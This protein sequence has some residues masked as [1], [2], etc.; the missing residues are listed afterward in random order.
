MH[1]KKHHLDSRLLMLIAYVERGN[2]D[3]MLETPETAQEIGVSTG[4]LNHGRLN[5]YGPPATYLSVKKIRYRR[6]E[7]LD[8]LRG[9]QE[10][11]EA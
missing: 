1:P 8:W 11:A 3:E 4:W 5:G 7:I 6:S 2:P 10:R 9:R